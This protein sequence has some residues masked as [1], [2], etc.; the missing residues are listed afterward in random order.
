MLEVWCC[1]WFYNAFGVS[2][3]FRSVVVVNGFKVVWFFFSFI[4]GFR[5]VCGFRGRYSGF[6]GVVQVVVRAVGVCR[7]VS[8]FWFARVFGLLKILGVC[9]E[10]KGCL[11][12]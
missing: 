8:G 2:G 1:Q 11:G 9:L 7:V 10:L 4:Q 5:A 6:E 12:I 3:L